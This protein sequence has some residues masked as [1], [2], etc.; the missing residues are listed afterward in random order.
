MKWPQ[1][2]LRLKQKK[3]Q[4]LQIGNNMAENTK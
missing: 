1:I 2:T 3:K 4:A